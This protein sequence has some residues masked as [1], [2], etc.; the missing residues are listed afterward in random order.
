MKGR[1]A[2]KI[3]VITGGG[4]GIGLAT[5]ECFAAE[6]AQVF[7]A[8]RRAELLEEAARRIGP[9]AVAVPCDVCRI[10]DLERLRSEI[11]RRTARV[12]V[13]FANAGSGG[14]L[15][16][17]GEI[18]PE[19]YDAVFGLNVKGLLFT[20]QT[21]LPL[22]RD[23]ASILLCSSVAAGMGTSG[24]SVY[25]ASKAAVRSFARSW[26]AELARRNIRINAICPG[27]VDTPAFQRAG[28]FRE[29]L[30]AKVPMGRAA[31]PEEIANAALF[32]ASDASTFITGIALPVDGGM[33]QV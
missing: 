19:Q 6:G 8:G 25:S 4:S 22:M 10:E 5:A 28:A 21:L 1:L 17:L 2:G 32:L 33:A 24:V 14:G 23:G 13:L 16:C 7:L 20:V 9:T 27:P 26:T 18:G 30:I 31:A 15:A 29:Q 12:D 11:E 3:A